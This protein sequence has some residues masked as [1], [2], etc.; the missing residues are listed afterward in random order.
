M[1]LEGEYLGMPVAIDDLDIPNQEFYQHCASGSLH[2]QYCPHC[3]L[4]RYPTTTACPWCA[5][6]EYEWRPVS[7][8]GTIYSYSEIHHAIQPIF[9]QFSPYMLVLVQLD[10]Q[11]DQ[12]NEHDGLRINGNLAHPTGELAD[13]EL[14]RS[15]GIGTRVRIVMHDMGGNMAL[16][17]WCLDESA[18][19]PPSPWRYAIE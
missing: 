11:I 15:V 1:A 2:L 12:P 6:A 8:R 9:K 14:V 18:E 5:R 17:L 4:V 16:P 3:D 10:E 13:P 7:G 19:Q